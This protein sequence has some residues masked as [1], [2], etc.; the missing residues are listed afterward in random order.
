MNCLKFVFDY[1]D[2]IVEF[3]G[4]VN[5]IINRLFLRTVFLLIKGQILF[6]YK[7]VLI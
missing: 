6:Q 7:I 4:L 2:H 3:F 5:Q 1:L